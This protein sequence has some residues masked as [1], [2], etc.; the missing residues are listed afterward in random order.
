[1]I[2]DIQSVLTQSPQSG[3]WKYDY[4]LRFEGYPFNHKR[5]YGRLGLNLK[6]RVKKALCVREKRPLAIEKIP[7]I[8]WELVLLLDNM[9]IFSARYSPRQAFNI[10]TIKCETCSNIRFLFQQRGRITL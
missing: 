1:M 8:Q 6:C 2:E 5:V 7:N 4:R 10:L 3:F 9:G